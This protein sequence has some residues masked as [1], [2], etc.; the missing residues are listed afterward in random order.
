MPRRRIVLWLLNRVAGPE[1]DR[2]A[3]LRALRHGF[4]GF[5]GNDV[6][7][8][9][10]PELPPSDVGVLM[11]EGGQ[12]DEYFVPITVKCIGDPTQIKLPDSAWKPIQEC[13]P[14]H[15]GPSAKFPWASYWVDT[16]NVGRKGA[17]PEV[18]MASKMGV[19]YY[20]ILQEVTERNPG[21]RHVLVGYSQGGLVARY[22]A[23]LDEHVFAN[24]LIDGVAVIDAPNF[25]SPLARPANAKNVVQSLALVL[26]GLGQLDEATFPGSA[27]KLRALAEA[28]QSLD[29]PWVLDFIDEALLTLLAD[30]KARE[31]KPGLF[32]FL[33]TARKW[34]SGLE[35][36]STDP[37]PTDPNPT[38]PNNVFAHEESAFYDLDI[39]LLVKAG[40]VLRAVNGY[41]LKLIKH[42]AIVGT[43]NELDTLI[44][45]GVRAVADAHGWLAGQ[46]GG[47][48]VRKLKEPLRRFLNISGEAY[49]NAM[50]EQEL[51]P[52]ADSPI[53]VRRRDFLTGIAANDGRF[54]FRTKIKIDAQAH[55]FVIPSAYQVIEGVT[56]TCLGNW[57]NPAAS[58][59][60]GADPRHDG[61]RSQEYLLEILRL[62]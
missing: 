61:K 16:R 17:M 28:P 54:R 5:G 12:A 38:N 40:S 47:I 37:N 3:M 41:P 19:G 14:H 44:K 34:L 59:I 2:G 11:H 52:P 55:D 32:G 46:I 4:L 51:H 21:S 42:A 43:D 56:P 9:Q 27:I 36:R 50:D 29:L 25:G 53:A 30:P 23:Y 49:R 57:I 35:R 8:G 45:A 33:K 58:H 7:L 62:M 48:V 26:A 39:E 31:K 13:Y 15:Y 20:R 10:R 18:R 6:V 1:W 60:S 24:A 22:L